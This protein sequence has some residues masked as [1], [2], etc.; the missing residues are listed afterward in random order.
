MGFDFRRFA[1]FLLDRRFKR[2][3]PVGRGARVMAAID[4]DIEPTRSRPPILDGDVV[5][6]ERLVR[7][8]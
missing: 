7:A 6:G 1:E 4:L 2:S 8:R 5:D 3:A